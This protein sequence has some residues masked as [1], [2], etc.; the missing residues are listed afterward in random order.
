MTPESHSELDPSQQKFTPAINLDDIHSADLEL[1]D[2]TFPPAESEPNYYQ[3]IVN[4]L[5][6]K[7]RENDLLNEAGNLDVQKK[8][9]TS[10][11]EILSRDYYKINLYDEQG[12]PMPS[13]ETDEELRE[14]YVLKTQQLIETII[15]EKRD[16]VFFL[17]KSARPVSWMV[18]ELWPLFVDDPDQKMPAMKFLNIDAND[19]MNRSLDNARPTE[20]E[21]MKFHSSSDIDTEIQQVYEHTAGGDESRPV[22]QHPNEFQRALVVD[23]VSVTGA[24][25]TFAERMIQSAFPDL[26]VDS[27]HWMSGNVQPVGQTGYK[28]MSTTQL[29]P[30]YNKNFVEGRG[31]GESAQNSVLSEP[32]VGGPKEPI[33]EALRTDIQLLAKDISAGRQAVRPL[34]GCYE[35]DPETGKED[36]SKPKYKLARFDR[37]RNRIIT[38]PYSA[39][40]Q[41]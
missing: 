30:W 26:D 19:I 2:E 33:S 4:H 11:Y 24:T 41:S 14:F 25:L 27:A 6:K 35:I 18:R 20:E 36:M 13:Y 7:R 10:N 31:I 15:E 34:I 8:F 9:A 16:I 40:S 37:N 5:H 29:P 17:D 12:I 28:S 23:E 3:N 38:P 21:I 39:E 1:P 22:P 32:Y